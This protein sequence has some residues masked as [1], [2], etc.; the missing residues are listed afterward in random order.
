[1]KRI[2]EHRCRFGLDNNYCLQPGCM[3]TI[4]HLQRAVELAYVTRNAQKKYF[5]TR[6][7]DDLIA[8]KSYESQL[9][10]KLAELGY[11]WRE[12]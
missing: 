6:R 1:M 4:E 2:Q 11:K 12:N 3:N 10:R 7:Q 5:K 9:D 8:S